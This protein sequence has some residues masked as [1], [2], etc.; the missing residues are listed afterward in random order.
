M[1]L[2]FN[3]VIFAV[4]FL[5]FITI[6]TFIITRKKKSVLTKKLKE[7]DK[8]SKLLAIDDLRKLIKKDPDNFEARDKLAELLIN[9]QSYLSAIKEY[10]TIIDHSQFNE[11]IKEVVYL[12]KIGNVF[13][14]MGNYEDAKK[15]Y[16]ITKSKEDLNVEANIKLGD[17]EMQ[18]NNF[19]KANIFYDLVFRIDPD[20]YD[21][22]KSYAICNFRLNKFKEANDKLVKYIQKKAD[23]EDALYY[24]AYSYYYL[25]NFDETVKY[26]MSLRLS[27][28]YSADAFYVL[29]NI[30]YNQRKYVQAIEDF[31][32]AILKGN[33][34]DIAKIA[35]INYLLAE[36]Y[37]KNHEIQKAT[38]YW[39]KV[40]DY[41][42]NYKDVKLKIENYSDVSSNFLLEMYLIGSVNQFIKICKM[43]V[44]YYIS[45]YS[46][47]RGNIKFLEINIRT[48]GS[49]EI[50]TEV[51]SGNFIEQNLFIFLRSSTTV[52]DITIREHYN[53]IKEKK[54]DKGICITAGNFSDSVKDFVESRM[55]K[56]FEKE[57]LVEILNKLSKDITKKK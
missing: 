56:L 24:L 26:F 2:I 37:L 10:L 16:L 18:K 22:L 43:F 46:S 11:K 47:L 9:N 49:L 53:N 40:Y 8:E 35:E 31:N 13:M 38:E 21:L 54:V 25:N 19:D 50:L 28:K 12:N 51:T 5:F 30:R 17:I 42:P 44:Q 33:N 15:Y 34:K 32:N 14:I 20:N 52:G 1:S 6:F 4:V 55:I 45:H 23:D 29:G 39:K 36:C 3:I 7:I 27:E 48:E 41:D 57:Q